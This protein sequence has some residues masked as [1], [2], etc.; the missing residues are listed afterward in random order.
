MTLQECKLFIEAWYE[1]KTLADVTAKTG[2]DRRAAS[3]MAARIRRDMGID[4]PRMKCGG[5]C[6]PKPELS[7]ADYG[8]LRRFAEACRVAK[9]IRQRYRS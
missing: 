8:D 1:A 2:M 9:E 3:N 6:F 4:L 7:K 5:T